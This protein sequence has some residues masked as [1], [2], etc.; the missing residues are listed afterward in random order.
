M[1]WKNLKI[2]CASFMLAAT[3]FAGTMDAG[4]VGP[5]GEVILYYK[6]GSSIIVMECAN[7]TVLNSRN[8]CVQ[9]SGTNAA[10]VPVQEFK[11]RLKTVLKLPIGNYSADMKRKIELF[12]KGKLDDV[13]EL[14]RQRGEVK[15]ALDR[16]QAFITSYGEANAD[17]GEKSRLEE[18]LQKIDEQLADNADLTNAIREINRLVDSLVDNVIA[19]NTL[20]KFVYS[21]Q[22]TG[23]EFNILRSYLQ[24]SGIS[25]AFANIPA[26]TFFMGSEKS[27]A[28]RFDDEKK[29]QVTI[30]KDFQFQVAPV[31]QLQYF[32][33]MGVNPSRFKDAQNCKKDHLVI[34]GTELCPNNPT[35]TVS[36]NDVQ[37]FIAKLNQG[38][39][40]YT[41]RLPTESEWEY[42]V[43]GGTIT[44]YAFGDD[45]SQLSDYAWYY[46]NSGNQTHAVCSTPKKT[47][48]FNNQELCDVHGNVW[49]WVQ[50]IYGDYPSS[51]VTDPKGASSGSYRVIRGGSWNNDPQY[52]RSAFRSNA[53]PGVRGDDVGFRLVR[54]PR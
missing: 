6:N 4:L 43:R 40:G 9:K 46:K 26:G 17:L 48:T 8:D 36:W 10:R 25:A 18:R 37:D 39:D 7:Y 28:G 52:L 19:S 23:F 45:A 16:I 54:T 34:N 31:T 14:E 20:S 12:K 41:Y 35:E 42:A 47:T 1:N 2:A 33:V 30:Q 44:A 21:Q 27:E 5:N 13:A 29:H 49:Q 32:L 3:A 38:N 11:N 24:A 15:S 51:N 53:G 22:K 50:D